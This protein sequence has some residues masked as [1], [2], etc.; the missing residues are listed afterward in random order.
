MLSST[1]HV[2][3]LLTSPLAEELP[4]HLHKYFHGKDK[5]TR[6]KNYWSSVLSVWCSHRS[7]N[8]IVTLQGRGVTNSV[9]EKLYRDAAAPS[10]P[11]D[12]LTLAALGDKSLANR[13]GYLPRHYDITENQLAPGVSPNSITRTSFRATTLWYQIPIDFSGMLGAST[14]DRLDTILGSCYKCVNPIAWTDFLHFH[15]W[16]VERWNSGKRWH[17]A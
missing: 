12:F 17:K 11:I 4:A 3:P 2:K 13:K 16:K 15:K 1:G 14:I 9:A 7:R 8:H 6:T 5:M 10:T